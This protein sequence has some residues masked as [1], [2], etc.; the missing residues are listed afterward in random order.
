M[1]CLWQCPFQITVITTDLKN[2]QHLFLEPK[3]DVAIAYL[4]RTIVGDTDRHQKQKTEP[5]Q[6]TM[7]LTTG[8]CGRS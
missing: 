4:S 2:L 1:K 6:D 8:N 7:D 5:P 3:A